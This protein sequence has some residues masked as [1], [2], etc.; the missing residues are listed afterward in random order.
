[1]S[2]PD[3]QEVRLR[4][5]F[6]RGSWQMKFVASD[7]RGRELGCLIGIRRTLDE[8]RARS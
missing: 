3:E 6:I 8:R 2:I 7:A 1:M 4:S 5:F